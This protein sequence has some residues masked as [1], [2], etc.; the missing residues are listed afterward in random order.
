MISGTD[1]NTQREIEKCN[2]SFLRICM[3]I[4]WQ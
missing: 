1:Q 3:N 2:A 4:L